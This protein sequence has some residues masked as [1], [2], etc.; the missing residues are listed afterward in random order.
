MTTLEIVPSTAAVKSGQAV[1]FRA[2]ARDENGV[3][4]PGVLYDWSVTDRSAGRIGLGGLFE[5]GQ[6]VGDFTAVVKVKAT[7]RLGR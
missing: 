1:Q 7:Q 5:A 4:V 6:A 3:Q 2:V